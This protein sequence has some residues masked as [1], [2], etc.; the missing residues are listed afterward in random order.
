MTFHTDW[1]SILP[2]TKFNNIIPMKN[3]RNSAIIF[4]IAALISAS[5]YADKYTAT[6]S[7]DWTTPGIWDKGTPPALATDTVAFAKGVT[8]DLNE[9]VTLAKIEYNGVGASDPSSIFNI[10]GATTNVNFTGKSDIWYNTRLNINVLGGSTLTFADLAWGNGGYSNMTV[11]DSTLNITKL[12]EMR[13][14]K[15]SDGAFLHVNGTVTELE[16]VKSYSS[17]LA[18]AGSASIQVNEAGTAYDNAGRMTIALDGA[19]MTVGSFLQINPSAAYAAALVDVKNSYLSTV[20]DLSLEQTGANSMSTVRLTDTAEAVISGKVNIKGSGLASKSS[21]YVIG[22]TLTQKG[23]GTEIAATGGASALLQVTGGGVFNFTKMNVNNTASSSNK[24][25]VYGA[26]SVIKNT[27]NNDVYI[28]SQNH[29]AKA[30][31]STSSLTFG[32]FDESNNFV[33]ADKGAFVANYQ[34]FVSESGELNFLLGA[35]NASDT[36]NS[37][38]DKAILQATYFKGILGDFNVDLTNVTGLE[39]GY[40]YFCLISSTQDISQG[41]DWGGGYVIDWTKINVTDGNTAIFDQ[42]YVEGNKFYLGVNIIPEPSTYAAI[43]GALALS[44]AIYRR[45]K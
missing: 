10:S 19:K 22:S 42:Y 31:D 12:S 1:N 41:K 29:N 32:G 15:V 5:V 26:G 18:F 4:S 11:T 3:I 16:G 20:G 35:S 30:S 21:V 2:T 6:S 27:G 39:E 40:Y 43:V 24:V 13:G 8:V 17:L 38:S 37:G 28:G 25:V 9:S 45:K 14:S 33:A 34:F 23:Q 36:K 44:F 7:G